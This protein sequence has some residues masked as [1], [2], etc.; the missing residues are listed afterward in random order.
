MVQNPLPAISTFN[1]FA[2]EQRDKFNQVVNRKT[3][4]APGLTI[5]PSVLLRADQG[6]H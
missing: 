4:K 3:V 2:I 6:I 5:P 1:Q